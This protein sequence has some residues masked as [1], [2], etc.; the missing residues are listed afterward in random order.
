MTEH[1]G[2]PDKLLLT[3][4]LRRKKTGFVANIRAM[5]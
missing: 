2:Y 1:A 3:L 4:N 5:Q